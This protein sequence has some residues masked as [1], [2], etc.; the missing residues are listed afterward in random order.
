MRYSS[1]RRYDY[2][3]RYSKYR[4]IT[5]DNE[6]Y[7]ETFNQSIIPKSEDDIFHIVESM[8]A[9]RPD[10]IAKIYYNDATW[11]WV[12]LLANNIVDPF[13]IDAGTILRIPPTST[14]YNNDGVLN[15]Y[16]YYL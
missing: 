12:I 4:Q 7:T 15:H 11:Y 5:V 3:S 8:Q 2:E 6:T 1:P 13:T 16:A 14:L 10:I 9:N